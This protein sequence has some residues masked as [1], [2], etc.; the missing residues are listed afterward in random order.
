MET[1]YI[2]IFS[3]YQ[4]RKTGE[5]VEIVACNCDDNG[6]RNETDWTTYIDSEGN[7]H[8]KEH[9]HVYLDFK[10]IQKMPDYLKQMLDQ[11]NSFSMKYPSSYNNRFYELTKELFLHKGCTLEE[12]MKIAKEF[13]DSTKDMY[14]NE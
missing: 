6:A 14:K 5:I 7:E 12:A 11:A 9:L 1:N 10:V 2:N 4:N 13:V 3:K 8:I